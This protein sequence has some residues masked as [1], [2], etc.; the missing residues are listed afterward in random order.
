MDAVITVVRLPFGLMALL[1]VAAAW[2]LALVAESVAALCTLTYLALSSKRDEAKV[3]WIQGYPHAIGM[4]VRSC[5]KVVHWVF[6]DDTPVG[7]DEVPASTLVIGSVVL[8]VVA[9][10]GLWY[11]NYR[12]ARAAR[13]APDR[14][15][16]E[17]VLAAEKRV[18][19]A[20]SLYDPTAADR[21]AVREGLQK[22]DV[23]KCPDSFRVA[24]GDYV[25]EWD[26]EKEN[27]N[28]Y[29]AFDRLKKQADEY[30]AAVP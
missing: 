24:F 2:L 9:S 16:I 25:R 19:G 5:A 22:I 8:V 12:A 6:N 11:W 28:L 1:V 27:R 30:D 3:S 23:S 26:K 10:G 15:A 29:S 4:G 7:R 20:T 21:R 18:R 13:L 17:E 14:A